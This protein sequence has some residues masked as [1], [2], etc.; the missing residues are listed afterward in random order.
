MELKN[1]LLPTLA[2]FIAVTAFN[3][4]FHGV[5]MDKVYLDNSHFFRPQDEIQ[6]HKIYFWIADL[7]Y[8]YA[9]CYVYSKGHEKKENIASQGLKYGLWIS[10]LV[11][12]PS[13]IVSCVIF[14]FPIALQLRWLIGYVIQSIIAGMVVSYVFTKKLK[15]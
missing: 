14:P 11:W 4:I 2:V 9:F 15:T 12:I 7:I 3:I 13:T 5:V 10:L 1:L 6:K 8:S